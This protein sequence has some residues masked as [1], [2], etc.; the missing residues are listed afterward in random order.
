MKK[1]YN[2]LFTV[3]ITFIGLTFISSCTD[4]LN[5]TPEDDQTVLSEELFE[6]ENAYKEVLAGVYA[7]LSLTGVIIYI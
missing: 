5:I 3:V 7:N 1:Y 6:D 4:D 2:K